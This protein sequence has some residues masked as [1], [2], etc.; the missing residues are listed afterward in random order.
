MNTP[1]EVRKENLTN[2]PVA[3][4]LLYNTVNNTTLFQ[5]HK[6]GLWGFVTGH[7]ENGEMPLDAMVREAWE[8]LGMKMLPHWLKPNGVF[9]PKSIEDVAEDKWF[10]LHMYTANYYD[11]FGFSL[12]E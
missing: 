8:E 9:Y 6:S 2:K 5:L 12:I 11:G 7:I 10:E 4:L 1:I 3:G